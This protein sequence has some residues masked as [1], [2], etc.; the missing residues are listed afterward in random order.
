[1]YILTVKARDSCD[2]DSARTLYSYG[3]AKASLFRKVPKI[4]G[5]RKSPKRAF[6]R[7]H[8]RFPGNFDILSDLLGIENVLRVK[9]KTRE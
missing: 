4:L 8:F 5:V 6:W 1:M 3:V 7:K 9:R 2:T